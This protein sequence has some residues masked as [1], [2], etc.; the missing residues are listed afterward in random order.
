MITGRWQDGRERYHGVVLCMA[1]YA[2]NIAWFK[3]YIYIVITLFDQEFNGTN[4]PMSII[5]KKPFEK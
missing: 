4:T 2:Q 5:F 1:K 3:H